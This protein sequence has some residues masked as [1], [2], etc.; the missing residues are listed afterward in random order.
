[1]KNIMREIPLHDNPIIRSVDIIWNYPHPINLDYA[2]AA[3][4]IFGDSF[5]RSLILK[6]G[7]RNIVLVHFKKIDIHALIMNDQQ[8]QLIDINDL[9]ITIL[10]KAYYFPYNPTESLGNENIIEDLNKS[11]GHIEVPISPSITDPQYIVT[12]AMNG[13]AIIITKEVGEETFKVWHFQSPT[14]HM[15]LLINFLDIYISRIHEILFVKDY[16]APGSLGIIGNETGHVC[17]DNYLYYDIKKEKWILK[18]IPLRY[19]EDYHD[20]NVIWKGIKYTFSKIK[21]HEKEIDFSKSLY[22]RSED[23]SNFI[24]KLIAEF[25]AR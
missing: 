17:A 14:I 10:G 1:M 22:D 18:C 2:M 13:C 24:G 8:L 20:S 6:S 4:L 25:K 9:E 7:I 21:K 16:A 5:D 19:I 23:K 15:K 3:K 11:I 12:G